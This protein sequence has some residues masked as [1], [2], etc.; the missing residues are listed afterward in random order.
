MK[1]PA[2]KI[3][4]NLKMP[5][6][7][8][9]N[10]FGLFLKID[11]EKNIADGF[12]YFSNLNKNYIN[13]VKQN[14]IVGLKIPVRFQFKPASKE[15]IASY[16]QRKFYSEGEEAELIICGETE[17][18]IILKDE[19]EFEYKV[20]KTLW[21]R[22]PKYPG[23][24]I[25]DKVICRAHKVMWGISYFDRV[26][27]PNP[28]FE[29]IEKWVQEDG[30]I[31]KTFREWIDY[32]DSDI[33]I[34]LKDDYSNCNANYI[35]SYLFLLEV[36]LKDS[37]ERLDFSYSFSLLKTIIFID[38]KLLS[39]G[40]LLT[41]SEKLRE[42]TKKNIEV[43]INRYEHW[44]NHL[45]KIKDSGID[46]IFE[47]TIKIL[48]S[49]LESQEELCENIFLINF[50][51]I[52]FQNDNIRYDLVEKL[53]N[54]LLKKN[55]LL[56][57]EPPFS[58]LLRAFADRRKY[59]R[60]QLFSTLNFQSPAI[61][62]HHPLLA[63]FIFLK[64]I[65]YRYCVYTRDILQSFIAKGSLLYYK[66]LFISDEKIK[67]KLIKDSLDL[68][69]GLN[70]TKED[71]D[72]ADYYREW[73]ITL[74]NTIARNY[75]LLFAL[76]MDE[77]DSIHYLLEARD[78]YRRAR[79]RRSFLLEYYI[80]Y[81]SIIVL[82]NKTTPDG[83]DRLIANTAVIHQKIIEDLK[84]AEIHSILN[85][86]DLFYGV[87]KL[88]GDNDQSSFETLLGITKLPLKEPQGFP[89]I[90]KLA[91]IILANNLIK[92]LLNTQY[93]FWSNIQEF[94]RAGEF[95]LP[96]DVT[97]LEEE[98]DQDAYNPIFNEENYKV[99]FKGSIAFHV[100]KYI[101]SKKVELSDKVRKS[102]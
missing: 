21:E 77:D 4:T 65:D 40:F 97:A 55:L 12:I 39:S 34:K 15:K 51:L 66:A 72:D 48:E 64:N 5:L 33:K 19:E 43:K 9:K 87:I 7:I 23:Q 44:T 71:F 101:Y 52:R 24:I 68:L 83:I 47:E 13:I 26:K 82:I 92:D 59:I 84:S 102:F 10:N 96:L 80:Q 20:I 14:K 1:Y 6:V 54:L 74:Y 70:I 30:I 94:L 31:T 8:G 69:I 35:F 67:V 41:Q 56:I 50:I 98:L 62:E 32:P 17:K 86:L 57:E 99:E 11:N 89:C 45:I 27:L 58:N 79:S 61:F 93:P 81:L 90:Q 22:G 75:E 95:V 60:K 18:H 88:I 73:S 3:S 36:Q 91:R 100:D 78:Y 2:G 46:S 25:G 29:L 63:H 85:Y 76:K 42:E 49:N 38:R 16:T 37:I 53:G 28:Y